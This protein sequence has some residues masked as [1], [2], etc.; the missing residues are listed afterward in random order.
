MPTK[1]CQR[2]GETKPLDAFHRDAR[3]PDGR[4]IYCR[5]CRGSKRR[6]HA[7]TPTHAQ[8][9][10]GDALRAAVVAEV[11]RIP[12]LRND[13]DVRRWFRRGGLLDDP[14]MPD[15]VHDVAYEVLLRSCGASPTAG[16]IG[17]KRRAAIDQR[18]RPMSA[19]PSVDAALFGDNDDWLM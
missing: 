8:P 1:T 12:P 6:K 15:A 3:K 5:A 2:C 16:V 4:H 13:Y 18:E 10:A 7:T 9:L 14:M 17:R 19:L 11:R